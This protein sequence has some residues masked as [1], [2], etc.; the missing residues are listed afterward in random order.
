MD[1]RSVSMLL[2]ISP[3]EGGSAGIVSRFDYFSFR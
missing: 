3:A 2:S 1:P